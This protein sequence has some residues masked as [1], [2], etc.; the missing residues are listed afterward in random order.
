MPAVELLAARRY[1]QFAHYSKDPLCYGLDNA[2]LDDEEVTEEDIAA[3]VDT[4]EDFI[5]GNTYTH[6]E[7]M[8]EFGL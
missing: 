4:E 7:M 1:F 6:E 2:P 5:E 3:F 8:K